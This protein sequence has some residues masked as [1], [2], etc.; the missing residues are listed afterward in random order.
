MK[1]NSDYQK[2][3]NEQL[4]KAIQNIKHLENIN[5]NQNEDQMND[6]RELKDKNKMLNKEIK[7]LKSDIA[8][9]KERESKLMK[10]LSAI[11]EKGID[12]EQI[13]IEEVINKKPDYNDVL[14]NKSKPKYI[15]ILLYYYYIKYLNI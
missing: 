15:L 8:K 7:E 9:L 12:I 14:I 1:V 6:K 3:Q 13:Y 2:Q 11:M 5:P 4:I 10:L